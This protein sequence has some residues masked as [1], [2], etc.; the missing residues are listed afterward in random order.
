M[1]RNLI[2]LVA[3]L[4]AEKNTA[5]AQA[6][7]LQAGRK[8]MPPPLGIPTTLKSDQITNLKRSDTE[9][10]KAARKNGTTGNDVAVYEK[11]LTKAPTAVT[12]APEGAIRSD[13]TRFQRR[14][15]CCPM[16]P[17]LAT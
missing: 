6:K 9:W 12:H 16:A 11:Y 2:L 5:S 17:M 7:Q 14:C 8:R 1:A 15:A 4:A 13:S 10:T 3:I